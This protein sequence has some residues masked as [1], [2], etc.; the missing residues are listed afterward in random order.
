MKAT[1]VLN[2]AFVVDK[3]DPRIY[4]GFIEHLGRAVYEGIYEPGHPEADRDGFRRDVLALIRE[5]DMPVMRYPGGN[6]VSGYNWED[7]IGPRG[8]RPVRLDLAWKALETNQFGLNEFVAWCRKAKTQPMMAINLGTRGIENA[9]N[10]LEYCNHPAGSQWS[11]LRRSH[12]FAQPHNIRLWC[13]GNEMDGSWQMGMKTA[14]EYAR[15]A[16]ETARLMRMYDDSLEFVVCGS[17]HVHQPWFGEY[18]LEVVKRCYH[19]AQYLSAHVYYNNHK[20]DTAH[21]LSKPDE[22][23]RQ[24]RQMAGICDAA[25][26]MLK[27]R[28]KMHICFDE[29]NVWFH[30]AG[31]EMKSKDWSF[32]RPILEDVYTMEDALVVGGM[33]MSLIRN[34]DRVKIACIAQ[35]VNVIAPIMTAKGAPAWRQTIFYPFLHA[36]QYGRGTSLRV[37]VDAPMYDNADKV[38][39]PYLDTAA[40][41][42]PNGRMVTIF[43]VNRNTDQELE[44]TVDLGGFSAT[45]VEQWLCMQ[46]RDLK[47]VNTRKKPNT[48]VP[49]AAKGARVR[50]GRLTARL[51]KVSWNVLRLP[52]R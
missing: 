31:D 51:P 21:F 23:D 3:I 39:T 26:T 17:S 6:F 32:A 22:M 4:G 14:S 19:M 27:S 25:G 8:Q 41:L 43:A 7:G 33:L 24:I 2:R 52:V 12:G 42:S 9:R 15:I 10:I 45:K 48:V 38:P 18:D 29:Y 36:S 28:K 35:A 20:N 40:V 44:L 1:A 30:S 16:E 13:L 37:A 5:L 47:A 50:N 11:D 34:A 46:N 49:F